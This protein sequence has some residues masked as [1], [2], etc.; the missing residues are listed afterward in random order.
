MIFLAAWR[1]PDVEDALAGFYGRHDPTRTWIGAGV[2][3]LVVPG[4][5]QSV[6]L[7]PLMARDRLGEVLGRALVDRRIVR[8]ERGIDLAHRAAQSRSFSS[9][10]PRSRPRA[11]R[12]FQTIVASS[13]FVVDSDFIA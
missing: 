10:L 9:E 5:A 3:T 7:Q 4:A 8:V 11:V 1:R 13:S 6:L 2:Q 12:V